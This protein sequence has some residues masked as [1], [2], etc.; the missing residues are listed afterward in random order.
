MRIFL[1]GLTPVVLAFA[2]LG[3]RPDDDSPLTLDE[4]YVHVRAAWSADGQQIAFTDRSTPGLGI[5]AIDSSGSNKR[6]IHAGDAL[7]LTW[8]PDGQWI[9]YQE[10]GAIH[11]TP[12]NIDNPEP[13]IQIIQSARPSWSPDGSRIAYVRSNNVIGNTIRVYTLQSGADIEVA[14]S[15]TSPVWR[16]DNSLI[17]VW[18][19]N[20]DDVTG[21]YRYSVFV[22][23]ADSVYQQEVYAFL[24]FEE[25]AFFSMTPD[26][27]YI[28]YSRRGGSER[29]QIRKISVLTDVDMALTTDGGEDPALSA[30]GQWIVYTRTAS[31]D[32]GLWKM[33]IDGT[34]KKQLTRP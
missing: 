26:G 15:G 10:M 32:G 34:E 21:A 20:I 8:S 18:S 23:S 25:C 9:A 4:A 12:V 14:T 3:C 27:L 29:T 22:T 28:I 30:D 31:Q 13:L 24:T 5:Y 16:P 17:L 6:L 1:S 7:G 11:R 19:R 2:I 33:R